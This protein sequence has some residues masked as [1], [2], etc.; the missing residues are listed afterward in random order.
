MKKCPYL[1]EQTFGGKISRVSETGEE[2]IV[3]L[4]LQTCDSRLV[5]NNNQYYS[6]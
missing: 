2:C 1:P 4:W 5:N 6:A 3:L